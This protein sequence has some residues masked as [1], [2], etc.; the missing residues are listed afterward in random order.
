MTKRSDRI[1]RAARLFVDVPFRLHGRDAAT[2]VDCIGLVALSLEAAGCAV[3]HI[4]PEGYSMRGGSQAAFEA[5]LR[6][7]GLR[8]VRSTRAGDVVLVLASVGQLHM[9][10]AT[11][12]GHIHAHAS[13]N[14]VVDMPGP[15]P[16]PVIS[17]WRLGR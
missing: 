6:E 8:R 11:G 4:I 14:K 1:V 17:R 5:A 2:G 15:S 9:M 12:D 7:A 10:I 3:R 13:L 16:W